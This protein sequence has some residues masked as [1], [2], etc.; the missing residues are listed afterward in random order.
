[1]RAAIAVLILSAIARAQSSG[2]NILSSSAILDRVAVVVGNTVITESEVLQQA[3]LEAFL[4]GASVELG[5]PVRR[6]AAERLVEQQLIRAEM[7]IG[8]Y[9]EPSAKEI[10]DML[11]NLKKER[12]AADT[13]YRAALERYGVTEEQLRRQLAWQLA[14]IRFTDLR[15]GAVLS[16]GANRSSPAGADVD[17]KLEGW[18]K[19]TRAATKIQFKPGAFQ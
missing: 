3:R 2:G 5:P 17:G 6:A 8:A 11:H 12:W 10:D 19:E 16:D 15:F 18:L 9:P 7:R 14:V 1:M 13:Q 4:N